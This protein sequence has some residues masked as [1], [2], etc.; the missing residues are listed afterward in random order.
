MPTRYLAY[1]DIHKTFANVREICIKWFVPKPFVRSLAWESSKHLL[2]ATFKVSQLNNRNTGKWWTF[3][4]AE[5]LFIYMKDETRHS[6]IM[7]LCGSILQTNCISSHSMQGIPSSGSSLQPCCPCNCS[8]KAIP[9]SWVTV[10]TKISYTLGE[11]LLTSMV[12]E[13]SYI[14]IHKT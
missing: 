12:Q 10:V 7:L 5:N 4:S 8:W 13:Q 3:H 6:I 2:Q 1:S 11:P 14:I 9:M